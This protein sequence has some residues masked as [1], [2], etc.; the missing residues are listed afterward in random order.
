[1]VTSSI[2]Y[3][4]SRFFNPHSIYTIKLA[5]R[6]ELITHN[7]D[8]AVLTL[9]N[10]KEIIETNLQTIHPNDS[11]GFVV[12]AIKNSNRNIF[13]VIDNDNQL[14]GLINLDDIRGIMFNHELYESIRVKDI[15]THPKEVVNTNDSMELVMDKFN[16][17]GVWNLPVIEDDKYVGFISRSTVFAAY[18]KLMVEFSED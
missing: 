12:R 6:G 13:P 11:L 10:L 1:M 3:M 8:K 16:N 2:A 5:K 7:K 15:M 9:I 14:I 4:T 18:R 17:S